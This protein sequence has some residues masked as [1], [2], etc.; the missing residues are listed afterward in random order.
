LSATA[1]GFVTQLETVDLTSSSL[2]WNVTL[3]RQ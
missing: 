1:D 2:A 3:A